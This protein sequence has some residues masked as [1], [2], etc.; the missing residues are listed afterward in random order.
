MVSEYLDVIA[1]LA[2]RC[3]GSSAGQTGTDDEDREFLAVQGGDQLEV[4]LSVIPLIGL[5]EPRHVGSVV[6]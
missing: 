3:G 2:Q 4:L 5:R 6:L 1:Q